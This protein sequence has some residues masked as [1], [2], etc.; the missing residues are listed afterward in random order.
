MASIQDGA[1]NSQNAKTIRRSIDE[2]TYRTVV[3][4]SPPGATEDELDHVLELEAGV[5]GLQCPPLP[6]DPLPSSISAST[7]ASDYPKPSSA[8]SQSTAPTS[9]SS[10]DR[11]HTYSP[12]PTNSL[13]RFASRSM[14]P[15]LFSYTEK[16]ASAFRNGF[17]RM[18]MFRKRMSGIS[19]VAFT[20]RSTDQ[21]LKDTAGVEQESIKETL[22]S[23]ASTNSSK[24][25]WPTPPSPPLAKTTTRDDGEEDKDAI[26][27][28]MDCVEFQVLQARQRDERDR[29][30]EYQRK[31]LADLRLE[32]ERLKKQKMEAQAFL[33][34]EAKI[35]VCTSPNSLHLLTNFPPE[36]KGNLRTGIPPTRSR[37]GPHL[38]TRVGKTHLPIPPPPHGGL[39]PH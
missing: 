37:N 35:K 11:R 3:L 17:R 14:T 6:V 13:Q 8:I 9:C 36:R 15:S 26:R 22:E 4:R 30:F 29:F 38:P 2:K 21:V 32:H 39:L 10:S 7:I 5:L 18:E 27:R 12:S 24:I 34:R 16:K 23:P 20:P 33:V 1:G 19:S 31:C 28:T 25:S